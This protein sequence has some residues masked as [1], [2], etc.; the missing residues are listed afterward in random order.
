[1][2]NLNTI[3]TQ[4]YYYCIDRRTY[5]NLSRSNESAAGMNTLKPA[6]NGCY[7]YTVQSITILFPFTAQKYMD[8]PISSCLC[9]PPNS[10]MDYRICSVRTWSFFCVTCAYTRGLGIPTASQHNIFD[11]EKLTIF[12]WAPD[13]IR[14]SVI[15]IL[16]PTLYHLS[17]PV[18]PGRS[19]HGH[20]GSK[21]SKPAQ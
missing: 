10:D 15:W 11:S 13:G 8:P 7:L 21:H 17:H 5:L 6:A 1:M 20:H 19:H 2:K 16:S 12:S 4:Y 3:I 14:T 18:T 9:N